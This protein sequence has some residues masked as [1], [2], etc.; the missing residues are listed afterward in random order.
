MRIGYAR[1]STTEQE[2]NLQIDALRKANCDII[3]EEK[4]SGGSM[5]RPILLEMLKKLKSGDVIIIY[6]LDRI[7]RNMRDL[8]T[9]AARIEEAGAEIKSITE[10]LDTTSAI[11]R[12]IF[13]ILGVFGEF[14][15]E[16]IKE[17]TR[18]GLKA[19]A[20]RGIIMGRKSAIEEHCR[21]ILQMWATGL[22]S[23]TDLSK[24]FNTHISNIK[25]LILR[26][27]VSQKR[28]MQQLDLV[29]A[30]N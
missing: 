9:I 1:V 12:M 7:A 30:C 3:L 17:R 22:V 6:K 16:V 11:G 26:H 19:A 29:A 2:T 21:E 25:R 14:E 20:A 8:L 5:S 27:G 4:A 23:K 18:A 24:R 10:M 28:P 13:Q 15:R